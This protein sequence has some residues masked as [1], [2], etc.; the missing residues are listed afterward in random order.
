MRFYLKLSV[1]IF[2]Q[3]KVSMKIKS[4]KPPKFSRKGVNKGEKPLPTVFRLQSKT[5]FLTYKGISEIGEKVTKEDL[6]NYLLNQN[7]NDLTLGPE[8]YLICQQTYESGQPHFHVILTYPKRKQILRQDFFDYLGIHPNIQPMRNM[9]AALDYVHKEDKAPI[10]NMDIAQQKR[11]A[12]ARDSSSLYQ[13]LQQQMKKDPFNFDVFKYCEDHNLSKQIYKTNYTKA[14]KLVKE[15]QKVYCNK[16]LTQKPGFRPITRALIQSKLT[17]TELALYD[18]WSGYQ[19]I[20]NYLNTMVLER[21]SRQQKSMNLLITGPP[22]TGKSALIWQRNPLLGRSSVVNHC[23]VYPMGMKDWFPDYKSDVYHCI[24]WNE[25]KLTSYS[26]DVILQLLDGNPVMLPSKGGGHKKID[27]P[28][29]IMTSNMT[30]DQMIHQKFSY[31]RSY[32]DMA[33]KNLAVRVQNVVIPH[34]YNLFLLQK[35]LLP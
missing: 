11:V 9:K 29:V 2:L 23:S 24:Y 7:P 31:N 6:A 8:K 27:N 28:L 21:G 35:L 10:T 14:V 20:V 25:A 3:K 12:R 17:P 26:Y 34:G 13:L 15:I 5:F 1:K 22:S 16:L 18:S 33:R 32:M 4:I 30:L 19:T